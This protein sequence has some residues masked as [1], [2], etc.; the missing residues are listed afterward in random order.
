[1]KKTN[2]QINSSSQRIANLPIDLSIESIKPSVGTIPSLVA[3]LND[4]YNC[5]PNTN[6]KPIVKHD[7]ISCKSMPMCNVSAMV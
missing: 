3:L 4:L 2:F 7:F 5:K 1:M 6:G